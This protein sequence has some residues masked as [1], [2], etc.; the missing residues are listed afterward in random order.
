VVRKMDGLLLCPSLPP[1]LPLSLLT[2]HLDVRDDHVVAP[3]ARDQ[4]QHSHGEE[5]EG[6]EV[7]QPLGPGK[8]GG[9][10]RREGGRVCV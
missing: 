3:D 7:H 9:E 2:Y 1:S 10:G 4:T 8:G 5:E 6:E